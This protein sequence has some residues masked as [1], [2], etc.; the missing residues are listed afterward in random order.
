MRFLYLLSRFTVF[1]CTIF[2]LRSLNVTAQDVKEYDRCFIDPALIACAPAIE[3]DA[4]SFYLVS[5]GKP[6]YLLLEGYWRDAGE[7]AAFIAGKHLLGATIN[8]LNILGC[9]FGKDE[10]GRAAVDY[11]QARL[12]IAVSAS[13]DITGKDGD[14]EL[15]VGRYTSVKATGNYGY[16]LQCTFGSYTDMLPVSWVSNGS[17]DGFTNISE[18]TQNDVGGKLYS[19]GANVVYSS[20]SG[21]QAGDTITIRGN[22]QNDNR[23]GP[24]VI[25]SVGSTALNSGP[26]M[27][28]VFPANDWG[29]ATYV[30]PPGT[31]AF[32]QLNITGATN[33]GVYVNID[34]VKAGRPACYTCNVDIAPD[35]SANTIFN[36]CPAVTYDLTTITAGNT[37]AGAELTWHT[38]TPASNANKIN[39]PAAV[40]N[41]SSS[42]FYAAFYSTAN[43][44]YSGIN[45]AATR[46][47]MADGDADCDGIGNYEDIDDDND[48]IVDGVE[49]DCK[50]SLRDFLAEIGGYD[51]YKYGLPTG[52]LT[53]SPAAGNT[54]WA[55]YIFNDSTELDVS[56]KYLNGDKADSIGF[57]GAATDVI[58][59]GAGFYNLTY[60]NGATDEPDGNVIIFRF[61][62]PANFNLA[63]TIG[64]VGG[65]GGGDEDYAFV[66]NNVALV[67]PGGLYNG[68]GSSQSAAGFVIQM[69]D[70]VEFRYRNITPVMHYGNASLIASGG[71]FCSSFNRDT[72]EDGVPNHLDLD[73][74]GDG[75]P[76]A[77]EAGTY[78]KPGVSDTAGTVRNGEGG[79]VTTS[80]PTDHAVIKGPYSDNGFADVLQTLSPGDTNSYRYNYT[81]GQAT[82]TTIQV[83]CA[84]VHNN[85][86][87]SDQTICLGSPANTL[88]GT[89]P[90]LT[91]TGAS[92]SYQWL[93]STV[94]ASSGFMAI[95]GATAKDYAPGTPAES[96]WYRRMVTGDTCIASMDTSAA[97]YIQVDN[98]TALPIHLLSFDAVLLPGG[99]GRI[100]WSD[101][102]EKAG[103]TYRLEKNS[104]GEPFGLLKEQ[105][106]RNGTGANSYAYLDGAL[107]HGYN[108]YRLC[109]VYPDGKKAYSPTRMLHYTGQS[110]K[111]GLYPNPAGSQLTFE[112]DLDKEES[113][114]RYWI[115][116]LSGRKNYAEYGRKGQKGRNR[117][118]LNVSDLAAGVYLFHYQVDSGTK[119]VMRF[120]KTQ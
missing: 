76:D 13:D 102:G 81:Y 14:W 88:Q 56:A 94:S 74:D 83:C 34:V 65:S 17:L 27:D 96:A 90:L 23:R 19:D 63:L 71:Y 61:I 46:I 105:P 120:S 113:L 41:G 4:G 98:C 5:H 11:L 60:H 32:D 7:I 101:A 40:A 89:V 80:I 33:N 3:V 9:E 6:G 57:G 31:P 45:G 25:T 58:Q 119:G 86:I 50:T 78:N 103:V 72:D 8:R 44:C 30:I 22:Y 59:S 82:D 85:T 55:T 66:V 116:D 2:L 109:T 37:P 118:V 100:T 92:P 24:L 35:L 38:G 70:T 43:N 53:T 20:S 64:A 87:G 84:A 91:R 111:A 48:G 114:I 108:Y 77:E 52:T 115:T 10:I 110:S 112:L 68:G 15:E 36:V 1:V 67:G 28:N 75:C 29:T 26:V 99:Q 51:V 95:A 16:N 62:A 104:N 73:S 69:G 49:L 97:V 47:V 117:F 21:F 54:S 18:N 93:R 42:S 106:V 12:G 79:N 107:Q 39:N